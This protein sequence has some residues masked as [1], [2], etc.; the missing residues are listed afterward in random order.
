MTYL[1]LQRKMLH[2]ICMYANLGRSVAGLKRPV[3]V[4]KAGDLESH[5]VYR[6][7]LYFLLMLRVCSTS[8]LYCPPVRRD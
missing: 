5:A 1:Q 3:F 2:S 4:W 8:K 7:R 6:I